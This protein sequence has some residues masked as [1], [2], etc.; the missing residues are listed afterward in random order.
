M[1]K[2]RYAMGAAALA[3]I[4]FAFATTNAA[5]AA[6]DEGHPAKP[7]PKTVSQPHH[8][9]AVV[10]D[11]TCTASSGTGW[12]Y[13]TNNNHGMRYWFNFGAYSACIGTVQGWQRHEQPQESLRVRVYWSAGSGTTHKSYFLPNVG[14]IQSPDLG[15]HRT[16]GSP[17]PQVCAAFVYSPSNSKAGQV[18]G[19]AT[20]YT[21]TT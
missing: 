17:T 9:G 16:F 7:A 19:N 3:P 13:S 5:V 4:T 20:C 12:H 6:V 18:I 21:V 14:G 15:I 2:V 1:K 8:N 11:T 10:P